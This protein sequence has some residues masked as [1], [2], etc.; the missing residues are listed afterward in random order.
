MTTLGKS[1]L[2]EWTVWL[3]CTPFSQDRWS[4]K[5]ARAEQIPIFD[6]CGTKTH[7]PVSSQTAGSTTDPLAG[8]RIE[9]EMLSPAYSNQHHA[10]TRAG[11][12]QDGIR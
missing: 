12:M 7:A 2:F 5:I 3:F 9:I 8:G 10:C 4:C 11:I 1:T 6:T